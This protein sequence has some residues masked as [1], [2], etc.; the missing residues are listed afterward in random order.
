MVSVR[1]QASSDYSECKLKAHNVSVN[2]EFGHHNRKYILSK[3]AGHFQNANLL[4]PF[5]KEKII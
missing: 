3:A 2:V 1:I 5:L 4:L